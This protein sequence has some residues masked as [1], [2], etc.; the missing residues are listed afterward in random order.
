MITAPDVHEHSSDSRTL[1][2]A[3]AD[4]RTG[5]DHRELWAHLGWQDIKQRYR[6]SVLG[7]I[8]ISI[9]MGVTAL[10]MGLLY[11][12][13]FQADIAELLP[14]ILVGLVVWELIRGC[15]I[16]G[17]EVFIANEGLIKQLPAPLSVH[18]YRLVWRQL[19]LLGHN[20]VIWLI[21]LA[22][23]RW[24]LHWSGL[25][26]LPALALLVVNGVW[27]A[28]V[29]GVVATRYRDVAP[30]LTSIVQLLF[31]MTPII[32]S[33]QVLLDNAAATGNDAIADRV[34]IAELNPLL[35]F[36]DIIRAPMLG[37][38]QQ[39]YHWVIVGSITVAGWALALLLLRNYRARVAYWV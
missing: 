17:S 4:L 2:R 5:F 19:L 36:L 21:L 6:R 22:I 34:R 3:V 35:H 29:F 30:I 39:L 20:M 12:V 37:E 9:S 13:L 14:H 15:I 1:A 31:F 7:P 16:E 18:V 10:A 27:V 26:A 8:W 28:I 24:D 23:F 38:D 11:S 25:L 33:E 32:W